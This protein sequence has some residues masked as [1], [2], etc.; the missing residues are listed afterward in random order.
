[1]SKQEGDT[2]HKC[3]HEALDLSWCDCSEETRI[4]LN[5]KLPYP[6]SCDGCGEVYAEYSLSMVD[7]VSMDNLFFGCR[8]CSADVLQDWMYYN[9]YEDSDG[10]EIKRL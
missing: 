9:D 8:Q 3:I 1:M 6:L 5:V 7:S 10:W 2:V 4:E